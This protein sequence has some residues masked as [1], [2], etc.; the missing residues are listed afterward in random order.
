MANE[1]L[2]FRAPKLREAREVSTSPC[3]SG[4]TLSVTFTFKLLLKLTFPSQAEPTNL[5]VPS[6]IS[7]G[8]VSPGRR[9]SHGKRNEEGKNVAANDAEARFAKDL[10]TSS[11]PAVSSFP[12]VWHCAV[13]RRR[14]TVYRRARCN[15]GLLRVRGVG[16]R[17]VVTVALR[18]NDG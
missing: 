17:G 18:E 1:N 9:L 3:K 2:A 6:S 16:C 15:R 8:P 10:A 7:R 4:T 12:A 14:R 11:R 5:H 13:A